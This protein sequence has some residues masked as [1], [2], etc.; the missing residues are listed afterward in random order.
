MEKNTTD[1]CIIGCGASGMAAAISAAQKSPSK[2]ICII[3]K[4]EIPGKKLYA[5]GNGRCNI[6]NRECMDSMDSDDVM[7]FFGSV[8]ISLREEEEG[9]IYPLSGQAADVVLALEKAM[10]VNNINIIVNST[11]TDAKKEKDH[12]IITYKDKKTKKENILISKKLLIA[13]GGKAGPQYGTSGDG[14]T[15]AK[16]MGH[17][18]SAAF[19]IL[20]PLECEGDF[21]LLAGVRT[22]AKATLMRKNKEVAQE[23]GRIQF[24][25]DGISGICIF[26]LSRH[27]RIEENAPWKKIM[28]EYSVLL[29]F[30]PE[31]REE[32][33]INELLKR[34]EIKGFKTEDLLISYL[35]RSLAAEILKKAG[36]EMTKPAS[37]LTEKEIKE[38]AAS[39]KALCFRIKGKKGWKSAQGTAGGIK[40]EEIDDNTMGSKII[41]GLYFAGEILDHD[42]PCG[43][44]NLHNAWKTGIKAGKAMV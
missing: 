12:F 22:P 44:Y 8:G 37:K 5:T 30:F 23:T 25:D 27:I 40:I 32:E 39:M 15:M 29:D 14:Y 35:N 16:K 20:T 24:T 19:P 9:R 33:L 13:C 26:D 18:I 28:A 38:V 3:E 11:V 17:T 42:G 34:K 41:K 31:K 21:T 4:K 6:S 10:E 36:T 7:S 43:G 1:I 2:D